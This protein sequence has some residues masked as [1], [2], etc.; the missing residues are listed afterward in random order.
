LQEV[1]DEA[2]D[3]TA[4]PHHHH[5]SHTQQQPQQQ[6]QYAAPDSDLEKAVA[7]GAAGGLTDWEC[8]KTRLEATSWKDACGRVCGAEKLGIPQQQVSNGFA[9]TPGICIVAMG[10]AGCAGQ[11]TSQLEAGCV[12]RRSWAYRSSR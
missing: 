10:A 12:G 1:T 5:N 3:A 7:S 11:A 2:L 4:A 6:Q 8:L 9:G